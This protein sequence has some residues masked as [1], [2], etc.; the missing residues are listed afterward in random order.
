MIDSKYSINL[1]IYS[2]RHQI[3]RTETPWQS[4]WKEFQCYNYSLWVNEPWILES[5]HSAL[6]NHIELSRQNVFTR[7]VSHSLIIHLTCCCDLTD[8]IIQLQDEPKT[9]KQKTQTCYAKDYWHSIL[10]PCEGLLY[11]YSNVT[12]PKTFL[13]LLFGKGSQKQFIGYGQKMN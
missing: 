7:I 1:I 2:G 5:V 12:M 8:V 11:V 4:M 10:S 6:Y 13:F 3:C 9:N